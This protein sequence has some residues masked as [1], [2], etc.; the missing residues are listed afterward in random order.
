MKVLAFVSSKG[1]SGKSTLAACIAVAAAGAG[2]TVI[3]VDTD[4]QGSLAAW[5]K[6]RVA[7]DLVHRSVEPADL[8][9]LVRRVRDRAIADL[10]V[11][12]TA[13]VAGTGA[14]LAAKAA[15]LTI[16]P[17][18]PTLTDLDA[19]RPTVE[20]LRRIEAPFAFVVSQVPTGALDRA[21]EAARALVPIGRVAPAFTASRVAYAD[22]LA[23]GTGVTESDPRGRAAEEIGKLWEWVD[24]ELRGSH[25]ST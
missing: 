2:R 22:A 21:R 20:A 1:G 13:G 24:A 18:R 23:E 3:L 16:V 4:A 19:M 5:G 25:G 6:R 11:I 12:D 15:D 8:P 7:Q 10:F 17:V 9:E 14:I